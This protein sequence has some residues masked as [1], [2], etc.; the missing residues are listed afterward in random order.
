MVGD[1]GG[2]IWNDVDWCGMVVNGVKWWGMV[3][4]RLELLQH[5]LALVAFL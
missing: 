3:G 5:H 1:F 2:I 4:N